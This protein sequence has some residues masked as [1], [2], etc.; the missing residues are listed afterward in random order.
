MMDIHCNGTEQSISLCESRVRVR[1][2]LEH[3]DAGVVCQ[4]QFPGYFVTIMRLI[5][6]ILTL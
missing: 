1:N 3:D 4:G 2:C 5:I 6:I